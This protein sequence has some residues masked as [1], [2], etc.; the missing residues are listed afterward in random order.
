MKPYGMAVNQQIVDTYVDRAVEEFRK[1]PLATK[2][3]RRF[4]DEIPD[5]FCLSALRH[6]E[7]P[8]NPEACRLLSILMIRQPGLFDF[9]SDPVGGTREKAIRVMKRMMAFDPSFDVRVAS[10][11]PDRG[12]MNHHTALHGRRATRVLDILDEV[13]AG[14][15]LL[16]VLSHLVQSDDKHLSA[17]ATLFVGKRVQSVQWA[18]NQLQHPDPRIRANAVESIWG[19]AQEEAIAVLENSARDKNNRVAGNGLMGLHILNQPVVF[20]FI[21]QLMN[22]RKWEFRT[23]AAWIMGRIGYPEF[24]ADLMILMK[25][26]NPFVRT[27]ARKAVIS[28]RRAEDSTAEAIAQRAQDLTAQEATTRLAAAEEAVQETIA[29]PGLRLDGLNYS[30]RKG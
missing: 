14:R 29:I 25:D 5:L 22:S 10:R 21:P 20:D 28:I 7:K 27:S 6:L 30:Y 26:E 4:S 19:L 13:S 24:M 23:T 11:L 17:K 9:L 16:P 15:R 18:A 2:L 3:L 8:D 12:G 1:N